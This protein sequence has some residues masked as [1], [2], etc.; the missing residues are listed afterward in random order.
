MLVKGENLKYLQ[1]HMKSM[2]FSTVV[3]VEHLF[4]LTRTFE[5]NAVNSCNMHKYQVE[6][7]HVDS[8]REDKRHGFFF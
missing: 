3:F 6:M 5:G 8:S 7:N 4:Y 1:F 2:I